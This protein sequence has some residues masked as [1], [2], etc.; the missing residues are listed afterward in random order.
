RIGEEVHIWSQSG[1][2]TISVELETIR[3][4]L[5]DN[6]AVGTSLQSAAIGLV[7]IERHRIVRVEKIRGINANKSAGGLQLEIIGSAQIGDVGIGRIHCQH[8]VVVAWAKA[9]A[10]N[11]E[12]Q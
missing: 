7:V 8:D 5:D 4:C 12:A 3:S 6:A 2:Q 11:G 1:D 9:R 10:A